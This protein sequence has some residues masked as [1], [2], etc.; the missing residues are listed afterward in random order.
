MYVI[1]FRPNLGREEDFGSR[2]G[3]G[4]GHGPNGT[5]AGRFIP[6][7][8]GRVDLPV[9]RAECLRHAALGF[10]YGAAFCSVS[11]SSSSLA[12]RA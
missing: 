11:S 10:R 12:R 5:A 1:T 9:A 4:G 6:V 2:N 8:R 7:R 3:G